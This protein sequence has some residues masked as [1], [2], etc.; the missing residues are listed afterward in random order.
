MIGSLVNYLVENLLIIVAG[1][2][3]L[4][5][6]QATGCLSKLLK[7]FTAKKKDN[8]GSNNKKK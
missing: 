6:L 5:F 4:K 3:A 7:S 1:L 2:L 8:E